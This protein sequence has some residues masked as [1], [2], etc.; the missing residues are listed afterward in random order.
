MEPD[1]VK[2]STS[3][4]NSNSICNH[5]QTKLGALA[6]LCTPRLRI[7]SSSLLAVTHKLLHFVHAYVVHRNFRDLDF[8]I[9]ISRLNC[10]SL[11]LRENP[12]QDGG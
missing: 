9:Y 8:H 6:K 12:K 4:D 7:P 5:D 2:R 10:I 1:E 3:V 11:R